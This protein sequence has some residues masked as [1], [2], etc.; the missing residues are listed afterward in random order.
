MA[1]W[2]LHGTSMQMFKMINYVCLYRNLTFILAFGLAFSS[3]FFIYN[4]S[5][6][7]KANLIISLIC[8]N[9][10]WLLTAHRIESRFFMLPALLA[11]ITVCP[12]FSPHPQLQFVHI[13]EYVHA[14][15]MMFPV[16]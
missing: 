9:F 15:H 12:H 8:L 4:Q 14:F 10:L 1:S 6:L 5:N 16:P 2:N 7:C 11:L 3:I 13:L